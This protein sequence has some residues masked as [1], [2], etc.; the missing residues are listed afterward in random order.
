MPFLASDFSGIIWY[1][2]AEGLY[3]IVCLA[4]FVGLILLCFRPCRRVAGIIGRISAVILFILYGLLFGFGGGITFSSPF[5][6]DDF[7]LLFGLIAPPL[8][9]TLLIWV[10]R[11]RQPSP[12]P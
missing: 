5:A 1:I 10:G 3:W 8:A 6:A 12:P 11:S 7:L 4:S 2:A 9:A